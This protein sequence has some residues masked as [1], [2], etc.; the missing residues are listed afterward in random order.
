[1]SWKQ[2]EFGKIAILSSD[3][4]NPAISNE[5]LPCIEL[6]HIDQITGRLLGMTC[7]NNQKAL[8]MSLRKIRYYMGNYDHI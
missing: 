8:R 5:N 3:K 4:F 2:Y 7:S 6:E 1:M